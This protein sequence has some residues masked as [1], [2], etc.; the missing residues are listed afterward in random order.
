M[1]TK[2]LF[3]SVANTQLETALF[4]KTEF[5]SVSVSLPS[6]CASEQQGEKE[7]EQHTC[8]GALWSELA[9]PGE[10]EPAELKLE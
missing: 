5:L 10:A 2:D 8:A 7:E 6:L 4:W 3:D 9:L 1:H